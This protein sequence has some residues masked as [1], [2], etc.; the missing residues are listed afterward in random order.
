MQTTNASNKEIAINSKYK[1]FVQNVDGNSFLILKK[2]Q[3]I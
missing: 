2:N 1:M 3:F